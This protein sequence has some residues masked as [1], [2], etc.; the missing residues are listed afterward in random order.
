LLTGLPLVE[1]IPNHREEIMN[2]YRSWAQEDVYWRDNFASRPYA[3]GRVYEEFRPAYH[4]G[5][6]SA[7]HHLGRSWNDVEGDLRTGWD[8]FEG[9]GPGGAR[10]EDIRDAVKEA[11]HRI[12]GEHDVDTSRMAEFER[13]RLA[14]GVPSSSKKRK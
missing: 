4:Y 3:V 13:E 7:N 8:K 12:T 14:G 10:W 9:R 5:F 1:D 2:E 11:W 6:E